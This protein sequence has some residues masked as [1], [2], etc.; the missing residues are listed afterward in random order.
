MKKNVNL[1]VTH[2]QFQNAEERALDEMAAMLEEKSN[3]PAECAQATSLMYFL[4]QVTTKIEGLLF[5]EDEE[6]FHVEFARWGDDVEADEAEDDFYSF[7]MGDNF[8]DDEV[9][10]VDEEEDGPDDRY[11]F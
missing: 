7:G 8:N 2:E 3:T 9:I 1:K 5:G 4:V 11:D 10:V 6:T